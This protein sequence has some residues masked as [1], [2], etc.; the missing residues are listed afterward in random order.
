MRAG[1]VAFLSPLLLSLLAPSVARAEADA[2]TLIR[3]MKPAWKK[4]SDFT[5]ELTKREL[6][7]KKLSDEEKIYAKFSKPFKVYIKYLTPPYKGREALYLGKDWNGG[8]IMATSGGAINV[9]VNLN[10]FGSLAMK[11]QHHPITHLGF[12]NTVKQAVTQLEL[13][14]KNGEVTLSVSGADTVDGRA[15]TKVEMAFDAKA[16]EEV[17]P[18][19]DDTW[20]SLAKTYK[21]DYYVL[22]HNNF[23]KK[24]DD[25]KNKIWVPRYYGSKMVYC[26][27]DATGLPIKAQTYDHAGNLYEEYSYTKFKVNVGLTDIDFSE[28]NSEYGF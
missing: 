19:K 18:T 28:E 10:P 26:V 3:N 4:V 14:L 2:E 8:E 11:G 13:G 7:G 5:A 17:T 25:P 9:T 16:G 6:F 21:S 27:D 20:F 22:I 1:A 12:D 24:P 23:K 15:C